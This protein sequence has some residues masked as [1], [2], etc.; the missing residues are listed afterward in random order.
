MSS[1]RELTFVGLDDPSQRGPYPG[2]VWVPCKLCPNQIVEHVSFTEHQSKKARW[3][4]LMLFADPGT[5]DCED[6]CG[7]C[8]SKV[9]LWCLDHRPELLRS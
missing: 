5:E 6:V 2:E 7:T 4:C 3:L 1:P 8:F 9:V